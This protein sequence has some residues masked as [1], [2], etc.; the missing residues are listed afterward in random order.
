M[1]SKRI[2]SYK[3]FIDDRINEGRFVDWVKDKFSKIGEYF[4]KLRGKALVAMA[5]SILPDELLE[6]IRLQAGSSVSE[7]VMTLEEV[8]HMGIGLKF[9]NDMLSPEELNALSDEEYDK[10]LQGISDELLF[11]V[12]IEGNVAE[13]D[14]KL[15][16]FL[17]SRGIEVNKEIVYEH[18]KSVENIY[19]KIDD[20]N[21]NEYAKKALRFAAM[22]VLFGMIVFKG[23]GTAYAAQTHADVDAGA[24]YFADTHG[25]DNGDH[26]HGGEKDKKDDPRSLWDKITGKKVSTS[27]RH[28]T[29]KQI[30][31]A[32]KAKKMSSEEY[33]KHL[34]EK[35]GWT[36][37]SVKSDTLHKIIQ[38]QKPDTLVHVTDL[39]FDI[40]GDQFLTGKFELSPYVK[41]EILA[42]IDNIS[43]KG[44]TI[45]NYAIESSTDKEPIKM[46]ND[47]LAQK[48]AEA[49]SDELVKLGISDSII[50]VKTLPEQGP[51]LYSK[52]MTA[53]ERMDAR[54]D[55][56]EFRYVKVH[57]L[58]YDKSIKVIPEVKK[59]FD[60]V[61][62]TY[63]FSKKIVTKPPHTPPHKGDKVKKSH[64]TK[65]NHGHGK[66]NVDK[67]WYGE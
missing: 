64:K 63:Y 7:S 28:Y 8:K 12:D 40:D 54:E 41:A 52:A 66:I 45:T 19:R 30:E 56:K 37:D 26:G 55:T 47:V 51:D 49:V 46:G 11:Q 42:E 5:A 27:H 33:L 20:L 9:D 13:H 50:T 36:L 53:K 43:A 25:D 15:H 32:A 34:Q 3:T 21:I 67:C 10:Y 1:N 29:D 14:K 6:Y 24:K 17:V 59:E 16:D 65:K 2:K 48:R 61:K 60:K 18:K 57:I 35:E 31:A 62:N 22:V 4:N 38:V 58:Y 23:A 39:S 44:G